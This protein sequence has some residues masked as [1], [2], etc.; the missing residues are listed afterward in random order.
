MTSILCD[1]VLKEV[2][3]VQILMVKFQLTLETLLT[4]LRIIR[5]KFILEKQNGSLRNH[6]CS[7][8]S[9]SLRLSSKAKRTSM[10]T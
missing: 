2:V 3:K 5:D 1:Q 10:E 6:K 7:K 9:T 4:F 8:E